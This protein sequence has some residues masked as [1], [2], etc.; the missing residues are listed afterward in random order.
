MRGHCDVLI[1]H[2]LPADERGVLE[3]AVYADALAQTLR[4]DLLGVHVDELI[5]ERG[6]ACIDNKNFHLSFSFL[7]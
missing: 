5:L 1:E 4:H 7:L 3:V 6:A 2:A